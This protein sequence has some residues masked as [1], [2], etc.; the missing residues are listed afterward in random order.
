[1]GPNFLKFLFI[2]DSKKECETDRQ[3]VS[4]VK[5]LQVLTW[6]IVGKQELLQMQISVSGLSM[7][8]F[9]PVAM[10]WGRRLKEQGCVQL[11]LQRSVITSKRKRFE[12]SQLR[13]L[14]G[15]PPGW[16]WKELLWMIPTLP[17]QTKDILEGL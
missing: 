12:R 13:L 10:N 1:M 4:V 17:S 7:S 8:L 14:M 5:V 15:V 6:I 16:H 11:T 9:S 3:T 2:S